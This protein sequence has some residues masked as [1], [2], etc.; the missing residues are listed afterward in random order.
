MN[1][2][3]PAVGPWSSEELGVLRTRVHQ[4]GRRKEICHDVSKSIG[5][6]P[7]AIHTKMYV[8]G[9]CALNDHEPTRK[10][11]SDGQ[12]RDGAGPLCLG[13][14][15][16]RYIAACLAQGGFHYTTRLRDGRLVTVRP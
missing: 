1:P 7:K 5:R 10:I 16:D 14:G 11:V 4:G 8:E 15:D 6:S 12:S 13:P 9:L 3:Y 2:D